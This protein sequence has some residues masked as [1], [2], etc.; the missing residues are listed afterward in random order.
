MSKKSIVYGLFCIVLILSF[1]LITGCGS[2]LN[3][4]SGLGNSQSLVTSH[5]SP[6]QPPSPP[7]A[8]KPLDRVKGQEASVKGEVRCRF[9]LLKAGILFLSLCKAL[10]PPAVLLI[11][12]IDLTAVVMMK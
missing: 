10:L 7:Q 5:Q 11:I 8:A 1:S 12:Y 2:S 3:Q 4:T 6:S 9:L